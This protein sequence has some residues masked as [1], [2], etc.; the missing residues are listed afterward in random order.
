MNLATALESGWSEVKEP[1][2]F[3]FKTI[4]DTL[5][6]TLLDLRMEKIEN[7]DVPTARF[8]YENGDLVKFRL[9]YDLRQ[10]MGRRHVGRRMLIAFDSEDSSTE[11]KGNKMKV[12]RMLLAPDS[13]SEAPYVATDADLDPRI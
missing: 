6:G 5:V 8:E 9:P 10:K 1:T 13:N 3:N 2:L 12:F 4:G 7:K 11:D